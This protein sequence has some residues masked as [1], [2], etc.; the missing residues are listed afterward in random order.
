LQVP[1]V[2]AL[3][4]G[5]G[6]VPVVVPAPACSVE[7]SYLLEITVAGVTTTT[8]RTTTRRGP[9]TECG[10]SGTQK[11][12]EVTLTFGDYLYGYVYSENDYVASACAATATRGGRTPT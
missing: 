11:V 8:T 3:A 7:E 9:F 5:L 1:D 10:F 6:P 2:K 12:Y 4:L